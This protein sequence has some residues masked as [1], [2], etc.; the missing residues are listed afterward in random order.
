MTDYPFATE[1]QREL[2]DG[3]RKILEKE[4][5]PRIHDLETENNGRGKFPVDVLK[6]L[7]QAGY[8]GIN[9]P[10]KWG[11]LGLDF[12]TQC[13]IYEEMSK[14]DVGFAFNFYCAGTKFN[15]IEKSGL[16]D[17]EKQA[18]ADRYLAGDVIGGFCLTEAQAGSDA[19]A[20]K[21]EAVFDEATNEWVINGTKTFVTN[22]PLSDFF[23]VFAKTDKTQ[24]ISKAVTAF[25]VEKERG[26]QVG[27]IETKMG[28]K[29]SETSEII[30]DNV[31][32]P[33]DHVIGQVGEGWKLSMEELHESRIMTMAFSLGIADA[34]VEY[35]VQYAKTRTAFGKRLIDHEGLAFKLADMQIRTE[36]SR[37]MVYEGARRICEGKPIGT[38]SSTTKVFVAEAAMQTTIDAVQVLGGYGYMK[39]YPVEKLMRDAKIFCIFDGTTEIQKMII[40]RTLD[41]MY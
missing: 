5:K 12:M 28:L 31:R 11:G 33:A 18:W 19:A 34:A 41:K 29:L 10:E 22:G 16:S 15:F 35:A 13:L 38:L 27:T 4:L 36:A 14:V 25:F 23:I 26:T 3:V 2:T 17:E 21:T 24:R 30:F 7:A 40:G 8:Y 20:I 32:V 39:D 1:E 6:T 37:C 9:I